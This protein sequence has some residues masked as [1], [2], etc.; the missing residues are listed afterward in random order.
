M[1]KRHRIFI[2]AA[3]Y[4]VSFFAT[5]PV[6]AREGLSFMPAGEYRVGF[7]AGGKIIVSDFDEDNTLDLAVVNRGAN[8][9]SI[10]LGQGDGTF[11]SSYDLGVGMSPFGVAA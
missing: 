6:R 8:T 3:L 5:L 9:V 7:D 2:T 1:T 4:L 11:V 10:L